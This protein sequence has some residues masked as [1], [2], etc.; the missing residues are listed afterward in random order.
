MTAYLGVLKLFF[1]GTY[2]EY[3]QIDPP[4]TI[5]YEWLGLI[6]DSYQFIAI[7]PS[8]PLVPIVFISSQFILNGLK[9]A[10]I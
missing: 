6:G 9:R 8:I 4:K 2:V 1:G 10:F 5:S 7:H 3:I